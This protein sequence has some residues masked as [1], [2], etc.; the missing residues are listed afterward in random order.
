MIKF[1][2]IA[3]AAF[4]LWKLFSGD[5]MKKNEKAEK[6]REKE[7][8]AGE[9]VKD[10]ICGTYVRKDGDIRVRNGEKVECF[11]SYECRDK[12]IKRLEGEK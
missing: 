1:V 10:P 5:Q 7:I 9:M 2:V 11:C 12:Y 4:V 3:I 6:V 8:K